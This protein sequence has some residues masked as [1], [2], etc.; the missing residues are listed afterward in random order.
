MG[1]I[2]SRDALEA[3]RR[4]AYAVAHEFGNLRTAVDGN[5]ELIARG[6]GDN[7]VLMR[8]VQN[9]LAATGQAAKFPQSLECFL[10]FPSQDGRMVD[11]STLNFGAIAPEIA[12]G[13]PP[14]YC[15]TTRLQRIVTALI[16]NAQDATLNHPG[17]IRA[18]IAVTS[19]EEADLAWMV[20]SPKMR[21]GQCLTVTVED[22]G[23]GMTETALLHCFEPAF[24]TRLRRRGQGLSEVYGIVCGAQE[25]GI[26]IWTSPNAGTRVTLYLPLKQK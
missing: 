10:G 9:I 20:H 17:A 24:S 5:A 25:G 14:V 7:A 21:A 8:R 2:V 4:L 16:E 15:S 22:E 23:E 19:V 1:E 12:P 18:S 11:I 6:H 13:I 3:C 26:G